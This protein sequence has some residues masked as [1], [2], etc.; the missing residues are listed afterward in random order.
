MALYVVDIDDNH[1]EEFSG[2]LGSFKKEEIDYFKEDNHEDLYK[3]MADLLA[4]SLA[5]RF[6]LDIEE[7]KK[8]FFDELDEFDENDIDEVLDEEFQ[9]NYRDFIESE[10]GLMYEYEL[11]I[12]KEY[13]EF[14]DFF[15][16][17]IYN[18]I[19]EEIRQVVLEFEGD[20]TATGFF[21]SEK[22]YKT[23]FNK[24]GCFYDSIITVKDFQEN[25]IKEAISLIQQDGKLKDIFLIDFDVDEDFDDDFD[26]YMQ[27]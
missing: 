19:E 26:D 16:F 17:K 14:Y 13:E 3:N 7:A 15:N 18:D 24:Y 27:N 5:R 22:G 21:I 23:I 2:Y 25:T 1:V 9:Q 10:D 4:R 12:E 11:R 8:E 6:N 20:A